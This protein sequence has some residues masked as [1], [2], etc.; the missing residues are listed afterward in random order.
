MADFLLLH[1]I[2]QRTSCA[3]GRHNMPPPSTPHAAAQHALRLRRPA[4]LASTS[5]GRHE[6]SRCTRQ[7]DVRRQTDVKCKC[8]CKK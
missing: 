1:I 2:A 5:C 3:R 8:K 7:T 6:Y 4:S